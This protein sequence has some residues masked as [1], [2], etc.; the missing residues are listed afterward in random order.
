MVNLMRR[1]PIVLSEERKEKKG[2]KRKLLVRMCAVEFCFSRRNRSG[3][4]SPIRR[5]SRS[6]FPPG[7]KKTPQHASFLRIPY[8]MGPLRDL[9]SPP[10]PPPLLL[11]IL[12]C[13][14]AL[15]LSLSLSL[16]LLS[17]FFVLFAGAGHMSNRGKHICIDGWDG[18]PT[19]LGHCC[20]SVIVKRNCQLKTK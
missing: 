6:E 1:C 2:R 13:A 8:Q 17:S 19:P 12:V 18:S 16:S 4:N 11:L 10:P 7:K 15:S 9:V 5:K 3:T 20:C 14:R